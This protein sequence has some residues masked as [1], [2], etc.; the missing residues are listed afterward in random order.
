MTEQRILERKRRAEER[1]LSRQNSDDDIAPEEE[2]DTNVQTE[3]AVSYDIAVVFTKRKS[4]QYVC[5]TL[6]SIL[7]RARF[8]NL[9]LSFSGVWNED[10]EYLR[11]L[12]PEMRAL[13]TAVYSAQ[14][15]A[16]ADDIVTYLD[17]RM[18]VSVVDGLKT[19]SEEDASMKLNP[20][21]GIVPQWYTMKNALNIVSPDTKRHLIVMEDDVVLAEDFDALAR[22]AILEAE[23]N[24]G[25]FALSMYV[26]DSA[27]MQISESGDVETLMRWGRPAHDPKWKSMTQHKTFMDAVADRLS[28][29]YFLI[30]VVSNFPRVERFVSQLVEDQMTRTEPRERGARPLIVDQYVWGQQ[31]VLYSADILHD[32]RA[33]Y[34]TCENKMQTMLRHVKAGAV[35]KITDEPCIKVADVFNANFIASRGD[36]MPFYTTKDSLV[37]HIG[38]SSTIQ[39][40]DGMTNQKYHMNMALGTVSEDYDDADALVIRDDRSLLPAAVTSAHGDTT[41]A[42]VTIESVFEDP[43]TMGIGARRPDEL[44]YDIVVIFTARESEQ[45]ICRTLRSIVNRARYSTLYLSF[46]GM[47]SDALTEIRASCPEMRSVQ[48]VVFSRRQAEEAAEIVDELSPFMKVYMNDNLATTDGPAVMKLSRAEKNVPQW[49]TMKNALNVV[50]PSGAQRH[51][52]VM[53]DDVVLAEDFD[54]LLRTALLEAEAQTPDGMFGLSLYVGDSVSVQ[55]DDNGET[56]ALLRWTDGKTAS[57]P[58]WKTFSETQSA[59]DVSDERAGAPA[60]GSDGDRIRGSRPL[61]IDKYVWGQQA[62]LYSAKILDSLREHFMACEQDTL[63]LLQ[64][65]REDDLDAVAVA[66][67]KQKKLCLEP[68]DTFNRVFFE[69]F[70]HH[71]PFYTTCDSLVQHI[72]L[73]SSIQNI[74][75]MANQKFHENVAL[76]TVSEDYDNTMARMIRESR[77][78]RRLKSQ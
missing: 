71:V 18:G 51:L 13:P 31:A 29:A 4:E 60:S 15:A 28:R 24:G 8:T 20:A 43:M 22:A 74:D 2:V 73:T 61:L 34:D 68:I 10:L 40:I 7:Q 75:G 62:V 45:Y 36:L 38:F 54:D 11:T 39:N 35:D 25:S 66:D 32:Y 37:Q 14:Q 59:M 41:A 49:Y 44:L 47:R 67:R 52:I 9:Y 58:Q 46:S 17:S 64:R 78:H 5:R 69:S 56:T 27:N 42:K 16:S 48:T 1:A 63:A 70:D 65:A 33:F 50:V 72:G 23:A 76:G 12:C 19:T 3:A 30:G 55:V 21:R 26:G 77:S 6:R 53:E 57:D